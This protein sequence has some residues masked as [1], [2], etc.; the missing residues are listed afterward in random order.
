METRQ[1]H[2]PVDD[3]VI[4]ADHQHD[5]FLVS[6]CGTWH[7]D[8]QS[9]ILPILF[10]YAGRAPHMILDISTLDYNWSDG[11]LQ[12]LIVEYWREADDVLVM[13]PPEH[14]RWV[15]WL[16]FDNYNTMIPARTC[17]GMLSIQCGDYTWRHG[18]ELDPTFSKVLTKLCL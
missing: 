17:P 7:A 9:P 6:V 5:T 13:T 1:I 3:V 14:P 18:E 12:I 2:T 8:G 11:F 15:D 16:I 10:E 4:Q